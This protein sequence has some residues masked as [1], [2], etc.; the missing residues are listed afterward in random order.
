[1]VLDVVGPPTTLY[2][3]VL[4]LRAVEEVRNSVIHLE[5]LA[6]AAFHLEPSTRTRTEGA[7]G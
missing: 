2:V 6:L 3:H 7:S 1:M 4:H 5:D